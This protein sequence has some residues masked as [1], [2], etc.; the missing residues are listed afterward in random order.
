MLG[1]SAAQASQ[2]LSIWSILVF[3]A[4]FTAGMT[5]VDTT[6]SVLMV[7]AYGWAFVKPIRK[8]YYN[9]TIT[10]VS[11]VVALLI[12]SV[13]A[14]GLIATHKQALG[15]RNPHPS[16]GYREPHRRRQS[17]RRDRDQG[18]KFDRWSL[19]QSPWLDLLRRLPLMSNFVEA[20]PRR[21][22]DRLVTRSV[23]R[24][25]KAF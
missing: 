14:L 3:P 20:P 19:L 16:L 6:D 22:H 5:L 9:L 24:C 11:A 25:D 4:L 7:G 21:A 2:G 8:L 17:L 12:G 15:P 13:E 18:R 23:R 1:I 10:A